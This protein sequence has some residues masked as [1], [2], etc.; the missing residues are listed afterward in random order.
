MSRRCIPSILS[1][2]F[3]LFRGLS[4]K[5]CDCLSSFMRLRSKV[6]IHRT[7]VATVRTFGLYPCHRCLIPKD[8]IPDVGKIYDDRRRDTASRVD[9]TARQFDIDSTRS[10]IYEKGDGVK[11]KAVENVLRDKSYVPTTVCYFLGIHSIDLSLTPKLECI[12]FAF[13]F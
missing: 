9:S 1:K 11:S 10:S 4:R 13:T 3:Y 2:N 8:K 12:F 7:R 5:V 6:E